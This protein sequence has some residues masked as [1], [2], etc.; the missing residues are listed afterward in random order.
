MN[1]PVRSQF[2]Y[3]GADC[4]NCGAPLDLADKFCHQCSQLNTT[5]RLALKD[6][7]LEFFANVFSYDSRTWRTIKHLLFK[8]GRVTRLY[9]QGQRTRYANPF[10]FFLSVCIIFFLMVQGAQVL[11]KY[12]GERS[13]LERSGIV[14]MA[15]EEK[16]P[17]ELQ[18][19]L[20]DITDQELEEMEGEGFI[21]KKIAAQLREERDQN[22][23]KLSDTSKNSS[24]KLNKVTKYS[25]Q[26]DLDAMN[27]FNRFFTQFEDYQNFV[28]NN[29][30]VKANE[31]LSK[32]GHKPSTYNAI[33]Y[34]RAVAMQ[35]IFQDPYTLGEVLIPKLPVFLFLFTPVITL[36]LWL[37]YARRD[38]NYM[39]HLVFSFNVQ[40]FIFLSLIIM[41][42][43]E[44][45]SFG[46]VVLYSFFF[47]L[48]GPFYLYK[49]MRNFYRQG[50]IKT[51]LKFLF[52]NFV[53]L[54]SVMLGL[55]LLIAVGIATY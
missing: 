28:K 19:E 23:R 33:L 55:L 43:V 16:T 5:K 24:F 51:I 10:R 52:I 27:R 37:L 32:L 39:E 53:Y 20:V 3:R 14:N 4:L 13:L 36:F 25:S 29:E 15:D 38:Y 31:A 8:P 50:R 45:L 6:F 18:K 41:M 21:Q 54:L 35:E 44:W 22:L 48:I 17:E 49:A 11:L 7:F 42:L 26:E 40:G 34:N 12:Q 9:V 2:K 47:S 46:Y 1:H 30:S